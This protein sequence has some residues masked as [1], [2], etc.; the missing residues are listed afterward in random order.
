[1]VDS[2]R[3]NLIREQ[4]RVLCREMTDLCH[5]IGTDEECTNAIGSKPFAITS[6]D[7]YTD[8]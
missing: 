1:M 6:V 4:G 2:Y 8:A 5:I 7:S 3:I